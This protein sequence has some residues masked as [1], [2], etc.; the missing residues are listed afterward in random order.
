MPIY[1]ALGVPELWLYM[2]E[3]VVFQKL[4]GGK[5]RVIERSLALPI[6]TSEIVTEF[7]EKGLTESSSAWFREVRDWVKEQKK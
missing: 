7:L 6:L 4:V 3:N 1:A 2:G 5:Y